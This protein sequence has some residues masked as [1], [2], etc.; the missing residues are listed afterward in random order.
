MHRRFLVQLTIYSGKNGVLSVL[1]VLA[2]GFNFLR[3]RLVLHCRCSR[4]PSRRI[5]FCPLLQVV[6]SHAPL[7]GVYE[8]L[9]RYGSLLKQAHINL[10]VQTHVIPILL[11]QNL[12]ALRVYFILV[13]THVPLVAKSGNG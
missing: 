4:N 2:D 12:E 8:H 11:L 13:D 9:R 6:H 5:L 3:R 10:L 7:G 1:N